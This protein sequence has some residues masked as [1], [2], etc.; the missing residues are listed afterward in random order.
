MTT[1]TF[2][3]AYKQEWASV[4]ELEHAVLRHLVEGGSV[5]WGV[6]YCH[7]DQQRT[8]EIGEAL[9]F[10]ETWR[11]IIVDDDGM[12]RITASGAKHLK[13]QKVGYP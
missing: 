12:V 6:L 9:L 4:R 7:F 2:N 13:M 1:Q 10:L 3:L 5:K 8:G 11:H